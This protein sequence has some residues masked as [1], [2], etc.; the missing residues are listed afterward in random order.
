MNDH[1]R[2]NPKTLDLTCTHCGTVEPLK[3]GLTT[4]LESQLS[5][6]KTTHGA[7]PEPVF[8]KGDVVSFCGE[9][10]VVDENFGDSG[11]V[12]IGGE[13]KCRWYW[14]FQGERVMPVKASH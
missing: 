5:G 3:P 13:G 2:V 6:F 8:K 12:I 7:C 10:A 1:I 14:M 4:S 9:E 11:T